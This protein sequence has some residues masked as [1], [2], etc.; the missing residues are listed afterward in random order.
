MTSVDAIAFLSEVVCRDFP[1]ENNV[2]VEGNNMT[3]HGGIAK[4]KEHSSVINPGAKS[5]SSPSA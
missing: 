1:D 2:T 4:W 5:T 3:R